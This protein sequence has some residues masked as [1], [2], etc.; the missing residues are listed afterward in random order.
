MARR[1]N[2][3]LFADS[4]MTFGE[5]LEELRTALAKAMIGLAVGFLI[6]LFVANYVVIWIQA[7]LTRSLEDFHIDRSVENLKKEYSAQGVEV[8]AEIEEFIRRKRFVFEKVYVEA[9]EFERVDKVLAEKSAAVAK[10]KTASTAP[11]R[12]AP[13]K[14]TAGDAGKTA[15]AQPAVPTDAKI[16]ARIAVPDRNR[17]EDATILGE[18]IPSPRALLVATRVW[19]PITTV[20]EALNAQ[21]A[22]MIWLKA[23]FVS[24]IIIASPYMFYHLWL[25][26]A[27]GLYPHEK[28][29]VFLYL[30]FSIILFLSGAG[31]A[32]FF[33]FDYVLEFLFSFN[34]AMNINI[35]PRISEWL[36]FVLIMPLGFGIAF[37]LPLVMLFLHR[38]G[39]FSIK[40]YLDK[41]RIAVL[42]IFVISMV[43]TPAD[44]VSMLFM[45]IPLTFLYFLGILMCKWMPRYKSPFAEGYEQ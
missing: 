40:A 7:P 16:D 14:P 24:G 10:A 8:S 20:V 32:F 37:Q 31:I 23:A 4:T 17:R 15:T 38:I 6:G 34:K 43:L 13:A 42:S 44:P 45:A 5:H 12:P 11:Q 2:D 1:P 29:F 3:D 27:A 18:D 30:P 33:V 21:E 25:F 41:W 39:I 28:K 36:S 9:D 22:F 26:V 35:T 19:R